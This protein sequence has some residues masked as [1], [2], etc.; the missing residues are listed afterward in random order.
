[1]RYDREAGGQEP[2]AAL[3]ARLIRD[4]TDFA[5]AEINLVRQTAMGRVGR[6]KLP[7]IL[8]VAGTMIV[9]GSITTILVGCALGLAR[10]LGPAGGGIV[11]GLVGLGVSGAMFLVAVRRFGTVFDDAEDK[12]A[13]AAAERIVERTRT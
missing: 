5:R 4:G 2:L 1:M 7:V 8:I 10:W 13:A 12:A 3:F 11:A 9:Q 6:V